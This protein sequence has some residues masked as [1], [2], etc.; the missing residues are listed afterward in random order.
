MLLSFGEEHLVAGV[1]ERREPMMLS[2]VRGRREAK[3]CSYRKEQ[4]SLVTDSN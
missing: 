2:L 1:R 4:A 3:G